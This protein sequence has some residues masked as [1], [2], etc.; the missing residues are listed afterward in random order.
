MVG[1]VTAQ[2]TNRILIAEAEVARQKA[3]I[4]RLEAQHADTA[5]A[6][7]LLSALKYTLKI[8]RRHHQPRLSVIHRE[9]SGA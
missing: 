6:K 4:G 3:V 5:D 9:A 8:L 2:R 7:S 1:P